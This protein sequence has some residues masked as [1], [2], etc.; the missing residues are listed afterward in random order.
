MQHHRHP[1]PPDPDEHE[2][3]RIMARIRISVRPT[4]KRKS[5][6]PFPSRS[7]KKGLIWIS[8]VRS[9]STKTNCIT[10]PMI[11]QMRAI[12]STMR[13]N[14]TI[15]GA[16]SGRDSTTPGGEVAFFEGISGGVRETDAPSHE[17]RNQGQAEPDTPPDRPEQA[18]GA[19]KSTV[20]SAECIHIFSHITHVEDDLRLINTLFW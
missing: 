3:E 15:S 2:D 20:Q 17:E 9:M 6:T 8:S 4:W 5:R 7:P 11:H 1:T 19:L 16:I 14:A 12:T 13:I 10:V 18:F